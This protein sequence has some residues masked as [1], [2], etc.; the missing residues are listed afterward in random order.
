[1]KYLSR[2]IISEYCNHVK[3]NFIVSIKCDNKGFI[4]LVTVLSV[5]GI[6]LALVFT[7]S[8]E[9]GLFYDQAL[10]KEYRMM[11]YYYAYDCIDQAILALAHDY[12]FKVTLAN[13]IEI[14]KYHC[15]IISIGRLEGESDNTRII[16]T[17][18]DFMK[19]YVYRQAVVLLYDHS[20][21]V[22][23]IE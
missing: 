23:S 22:V 21:E 2:N 12:F 8:I 5:A 10:R 4:A 14:K 16:S 9:S 3:Y 20:L 17:R 15:S 11:N 13:P 1:M 18:G 19:A 6:L 7:S